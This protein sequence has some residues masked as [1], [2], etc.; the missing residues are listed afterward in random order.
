MCVPRK[1]AKCVDGGGQPQLTGDGMIVRCGNAFRRSFRA[2]TGT[3][4]GAPCLQW[5]PR[6][7]GAGRLSARFVARQR[8]GGFRWAFRTDCA[9]TAHRRIGSA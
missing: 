6:F 8:V 3:S 9:R 1:A 5:W 2:A 7:F 4:L